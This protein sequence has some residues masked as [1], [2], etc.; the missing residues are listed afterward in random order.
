MA[1]GKRDYY[2]VLG[3]GRQAAAD[4]VKKAYRRL[5]MQYHPDRNQGDKAAETKFKEISEAYE[6][7]SDTEKRRQYDQFGHDGLK[8]SF[9][10]GGFDFSRDFT[11]VSDLQDMFGSLFG[12]GGGMF[13]DLFGGGGRRSSRTG[14]QQGAD[15]RFDLEISFEEAMFGSHQEITLPI[16]EQCS[17]CSGTGSEPGSKEE[18]CRHCG[19]R[20]AVVSSSGFFQVRQTCP[21]CSGSGRIITKPCR[22]CRGTGRQKGRKRITLRIPPGVETG[23]RL[24]LAGRGEGG[25]RGAPAGDLYVILHVRPHDLFHRE[26]GP[27]ILCEAPVPMHIAALGGDVDIP[28]PDGFARLKIEAGTET[29]RM[30]RLRGKGAPSVDGHGRGDLHVRVIVEVP[31]HLSSKQKKALKDFSDACT[32]ENYPLAHKLRAR[33]EEFFKVRDS[34]N[35]AKTET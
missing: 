26:E 25:V 16:A 31:N 15:L 29:G 9:G 2:E 34:L 5:A 18:A 23:S 19:G 3:V 32:E 8:S 11:H 27:D 7:L 17:T 35:Q 22:D 13:E 1:T 24:R 21:V 33:S 12:E 28:T 4:E 10:P 6:V 20:G 30:F 14:P